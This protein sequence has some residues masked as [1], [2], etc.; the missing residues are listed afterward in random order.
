MKSLHAP[1]PFRWPFPAGSW[2]RGSWSTRPA[3]PAA[4]AV[5][6]ADRGAAGAVAADAVCV[7]IGATENLAAAANPAAAAPVHAVASTAAPPVATPQ[8]GASTAASPEAPTTA[9]AP[10]HTLT[11]KAMIIDVLMVLSWGASIPVLMWLG[12]IAGF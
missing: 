7:S 6:A 8:A 3:M 1:L 2:L 9:A 4:G 5:R 10:A 11:R 12:A